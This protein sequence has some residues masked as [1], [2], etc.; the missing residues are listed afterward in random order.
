MNLIS[1]LRIHTIGFNDLT[2]FSK[3]VW[4]LLF[5]PFVVFRVVLSLSLNDKISYL[6]SNAA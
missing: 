4:K 5:C 2:L 6:F 1:H 3:K